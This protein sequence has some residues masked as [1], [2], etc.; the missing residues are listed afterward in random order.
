M[1]STNPS[2]L[3][4]LRQK[5]SGGLP[6]FPW[7]VAYSGGRD[8]GTLLWALSR[9]VPPESL[10]ALHVDHGWRTRAEREAELTLAAGW[11]RRLGVT[12]RN[13][14]AP[15]EPVRTEA[16]AREHRYACF[17]QFL[18][19]HPG[20]PVF[21]AHHADDQAE[22]VLMRVLRGRSWRGLGGMA[23]RRGP[24][25][26]PWL[27]VRAGAIAR[28]AERENIPWH[29]DSTNAS[30]RWTRNH[31]RLVV[32]PELERRFPRAVEALGAFAGAWRLRAPAASLR[33]SWT[34][35]A[36]RA[37]V[38]F[39][40]W[41]R[42]DGLER[43]MQ[44]EAAC[45]ALGFPRPPSRR[46]L[47]RASQSVAAEGAG[48]SLTRSGP[49]VVWRRVAQIPA[50][51]YFVSTEPDTEYD[52]GSYRMRWSLQACEGSLRIPA[53][54]HSGLIWR[55]AVPGMAFRSRGEGD[56]GKAK[57]RRRLGPLHPDRC[58]LV[59]QGNRI[60]AV[61]DPAARSVLWSD[62]FGKLNKT[63]IFVTLVPRSEYERR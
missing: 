58:A 9:L 13:F 27:G 7:G 5:L 52:L 37:A 59:V 26:R 4:V 45:A 3:D 60:R 18:A 46:F 24:Y 56:W 11:C 17:G 25:W 35:D 16:A 8:S 51:E 63:G 29:A 21:L 31:L 47:E 34:V 62:E 28:T 10:V 43:Q 32:F 44:L 15:S 12:L 40:E 61:I 6:P 53:D 30:S 19:E 41:D 1:P 39:A 50:M 38:P 49:L 57:R 22:T 42:W 55:S 36:A 33:E 48:W 20:A 54:P 23:E 2:P 14:P